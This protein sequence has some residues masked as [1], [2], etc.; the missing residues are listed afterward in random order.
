MALMNKMEFIK[1]QENFYKLV[2][3]LKSEVYLKYIANKRNI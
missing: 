3:D 1:L 2:E